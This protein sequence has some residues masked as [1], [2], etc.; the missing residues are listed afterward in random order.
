M[1]NIPSIEE[2]DAEIAKAVGNEEFNL[3]IGGIH[4]GNDRKTPVIGVDQNLLV[5]FTSSRAH[6]L[7]SERPRNR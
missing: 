6:P 7:S 5:G 2:F 4:R 3:T 1:E